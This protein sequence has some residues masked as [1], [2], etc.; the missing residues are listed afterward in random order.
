MADQKNATLGGRLRRLPRD[1]TLAFVIATSILAIAAA[2]LAIVAVGRVQQ[3]GANIASAATE[4]VAEQLGATPVAISQRLDAVSSEVTRLATALETTRDELA[5]AA[6]ADLIAI[7]R[8]LAQLQE[9]ISAATAA[10]PELINSA[11]RQA[12]AELGNALA[13]AR[14]CEHAQE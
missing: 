13:H 1:F 7:E 11:I 8:R 12:G 6:R 9:T 4:A 2:V 3:A 5:P 10:G 14:S